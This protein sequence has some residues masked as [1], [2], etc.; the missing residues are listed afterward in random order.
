MVQKGDT[1]C[2]TTFYLDTKDGE[3]SI[4]FYLASLVALEDGKDAANMDNTCKYSK[5]EAEELCKEVIK[6]VGMDKDYSVFSVENSASVM[7]SKGGTSYD[8]Y[9]IK[10]TRSVN[11]I[12][13][14]N[15]LYDGTIDK[16]EITD[17]PYAYEAM[18]FVVTDD[19]IVSLNWDSPMKQ[20]E[21][22]VDN[23][24]L[25][26]YSDI[27]TI[28]KEHALV[29]YASTTEPLTINLSEIRF[30]LMRVKDKDNKNEFTMVPAWDFIGDLYGRTTIMTINAIDGSILNRSYGY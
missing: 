25:L 7:P 1:Y 24:K 4:P 11:G 30:G 27:E 10:F 26:P 17:Y 9:Y 3:S 19:G 20:G 16:E 6:K 23:V 29:K 12:S 21:T 28:F 2:N 5:E 18:N 8:G 22:T 14:T 15:D 13:E